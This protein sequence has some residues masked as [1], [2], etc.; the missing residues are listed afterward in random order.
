MRRQTDGFSFA[1]CNVLQFIREEKILQKQHS[2]DNCTNWSCHR[3]TI[4][5]FYYLF[6]Y[7]ESQISSFVSHFRTVRLVCSNNTLSPRGVGTSP[8]LKRVSGFHSSYFVL[9]KEG[10]VVIRPLG[11]ILWMAGRK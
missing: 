9:R 6:L 3:N 5:L 2:A 10:I 11:P 1:A 7:F 8:S 4:C